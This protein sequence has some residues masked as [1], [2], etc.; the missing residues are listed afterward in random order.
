M[1]M[2]KRLQLIAG[3][4]SMIDGSDLKTYLKSIQD[5]WGMGDAVAVNLVE[6]KT[7]VSLEEHAKLARYGF[8]S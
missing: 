6:R 4:L 2:P 7:A 8:A 3:E 5:S 1:T